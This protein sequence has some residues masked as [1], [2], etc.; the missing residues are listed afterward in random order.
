MWTWHHYV[1]WKIYICVCSHV[2]IMSFW[3]KKVR[4]CVLKHELIV[5][6]KESRRKRVWSTFVF[7]PDKMK[8]TGEIYRAWGAKIYECFFACCIIVS[9]EHLVARDTNTTKTFCS[10]DGQRFKVYWKMR[11]IWLIC[12]WL[13]RP[14]FSFIE[15]FPSL[16]HLNGFRWAMGIIGMPLFKCSPTWVA[17]CIKDLVQY[18]GNRKK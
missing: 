17:G 6:R 18:S 1:N 9:A 4:K 8:I 15:H 10:S 16:L 5:R 13:V 11:I 14:F 3:K 2:T 7:C 12:E